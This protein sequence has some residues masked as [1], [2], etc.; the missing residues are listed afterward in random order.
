LHD[1]KVYL[2]N[3][4]EVKSYLRA[5]DAQTGKEV[6][7]VERDEKSNWATPFVWKHQGGAE[8]VTAGS[9]AVRSDSLKG[10][11]LWGLQEVSVLNIATPFAAGGLL[12]ATS[13][14]VLD[15]HRP[16]YAVKPG[17][18]GDISLKL[19]ETANESVAWSQPL[20]GP[21][22]PTPVAYEGKVYVL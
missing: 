10:E 12:Y 22:H 6:F 17:A 5:L 15:S 18:K 19:G 7:R 21:Y 16:L 9:G 1:G 2:V 14:Y 3:D 13:G 11:P 4:N 20:A 8:I